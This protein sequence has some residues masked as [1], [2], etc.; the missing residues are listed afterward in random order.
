MRVRAGRRAQ[1]AGVNAAY[2][3]HMVVVMRCGLSVVM[4]VVRARC[5]LGVARSRCR[6]NYT[7]GVVS[8]TRVVRGSLS[9]YR[10]HSQ[11]GKNDEFLHNLNC[12]NGC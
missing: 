4:M 5:G 10:K 6:L 12:V 11:Y 3:V 8:R 7:R 9:C 1:R 2:T